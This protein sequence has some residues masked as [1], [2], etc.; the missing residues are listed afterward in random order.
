[1]ESSGNGGADPELRRSPIARCDLTTDV[2]PFFL[3]SA[4]PDTRVL[5]GLKGEFQTTNAHIALGADLLGPVNLQEGLARGADREEKLWIGIAA[6]GF[7]AP[8]VIG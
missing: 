2:A 4:T 5:V 3:R 6:D 8:A 1:L 7:M